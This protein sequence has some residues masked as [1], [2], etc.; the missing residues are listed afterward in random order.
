MLRAPP[1]NPPVLLLLSASV[2]LFGSH[3]ASAQ[4]NLVPNWNFADPTPLK[5]W[6]VDFPYQDWY[7]KNVSYV[8]QTMMDG[9]A[10]RDDR[11]PSRHRRERGR[12][13]RD[14][15]GAGG[16]AGVEPAIVTITPVSTVTVFPA[17]TTAPPA[18]RRVTLLTKSTI[19]LLP[20]A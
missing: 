10:L 7:K 1:M 11:T 4:Q 12:Q 6:R 18:L 17:M 16:V 8:K 14:R 19:P 3:P 13:G 9:E 15:A 20:G 5:G 2:L